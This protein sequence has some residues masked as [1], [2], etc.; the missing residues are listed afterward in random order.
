MLIYLTTGYLF[1]L[2]IHPEISKHERAKKYRWL[3]LSIAH[4]IALLLWPILL[5][6][7]LKQK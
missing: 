3:H 2:Y 1:T 7:H 4:L 6:S 5:F